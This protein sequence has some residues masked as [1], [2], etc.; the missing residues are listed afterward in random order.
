MYGIMT[1]TLTSRGQLTIPAAVR[2]RLG[3][4][5]GSKVRFVFPKGEKHPLRVELSAQTLPVTALEGLFPKPERA[6]TLEEMDEAIGHGREKSW[7]W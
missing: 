6:V 7:E 1:S 4:N 2:K 3:L 5:A